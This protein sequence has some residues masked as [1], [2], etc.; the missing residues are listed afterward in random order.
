MENAMDREAAE[1]DGQSP[2]IRNFERGE[3]CLQSLMPLMNTPFP[4]GSCMDYIRK[5]ADGP[6]KKIALAE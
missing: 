5:M 6:Q 2:A 1:K 4:P 3:D